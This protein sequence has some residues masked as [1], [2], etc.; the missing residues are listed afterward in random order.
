MTRI[1]VALL[2]S[3]TMGGFLIALGWIGM[4]FALFHDTELSELYSIA[5]ANMDLLNEALKP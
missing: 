1:L 5:M 4:Y 3:L 2:P